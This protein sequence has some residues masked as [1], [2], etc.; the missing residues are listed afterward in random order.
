MVAGWNVAVSGYSVP[1]LARSAFLGRSLRRC[2]AMVALIPA[3][4]FR[5]VYDNLCR[6][7]LRVR[8]HHFVCVIH[9][10]AY[11][12]STGYTSK[13][14]V[15]TIDTNCFCFFTKPEGAQHS[16]CSSIRPPGMWLIT[17]TSWDT[18]A[19]CTRVDEKQ[20][21]QTFV[22]TLL[23]YADPNHKPA[24]ESNPELWRAAVKS[25]ANDSPTESAS[26]IWPVGTDLRL[27]IATVSIPAWFCARSL[28]RP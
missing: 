6:G 26:V 23:Q 18:T 5:T 3:R 7:D 28:A 17:K 8:V 25:L 9:G 22:Q 4:N 20:I 24:G 16:A 13:R 21:S 12:Q 10:V 2:R 15:L 14:P 11:S 27:K 1:T 19:H